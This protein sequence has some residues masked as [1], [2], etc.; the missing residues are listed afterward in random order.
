MKAIFALAAWMFMF[1]GAPAL[2]NNYGAI[3]YDRSTDSWGASYD[4]PSQQAANV[5]ALRECRKHGSHCAVVVRF[6]G[7]LCAA[8]AVGLGS[9]RLGKRF[10]PLVRRSA[11]GFCV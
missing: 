8:Y 3:A 1:S 6:W 4:Y 9:R 2:A 5:R 11:G 10:Q 7:G